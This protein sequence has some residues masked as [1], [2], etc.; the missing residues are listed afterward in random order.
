MWY[1]FSGQIILI[2]CISD[3]AFLLG[4][5]TCFIWLFWS[6]ILIVCISDKAFLLG[7]VTCLIW[8]FWS[9][10]YYFMYVWQSLFAES[11]YILIL[12]YVYLTK[13]LRLGQITCLI[14]LFWTYHFGVF[15]IVKCAFLELLG[16]IMNLFINSVLESMVCLQ[17]NWMIFC[18]CFV[19]LN[20]V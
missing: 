10:H 15:G 7:Q 8:L 6:Y 2:L 4:Q 3:K 13:P 14:W 12:F 5:I 20:S 17:K 19:F 1:D 16:G 18:F 11:D 9:Y